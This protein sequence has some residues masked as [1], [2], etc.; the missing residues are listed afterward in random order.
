MPA[1]RGWFVVAR[2]EE[3]PQISPTVSPGSSACLRE[4]TSRTTEREIAHPRLT[5]PGPGDYMLDV[6]CDAAGSFQQT[7]VFTCPAAAS[8]DELSESVGLRHALAPYTF[9]FYPN[10]NG[11][12]SG[13]RT[14][15][16]SVR[17][18]R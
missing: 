2:V 4:I 1:Q 13:G 14:R 12:R 5:A 8:R 18:I 10:R 6:E 7:A 11:Y 16:F 9:G 17:E 3:T 15:F